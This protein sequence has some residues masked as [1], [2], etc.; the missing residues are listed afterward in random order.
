MSYP[1]RLQIP[2]QVRGV[3]IKESEGQS[4]RS[5][6]EDEDETPSDVPI[7]LRLREGDPLPNVSL[8]KLFSLGL[9]V[10]VLKGHSGYTLV[11]RFV[12]YI[13]KVS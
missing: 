10:Q 3:R 8:P 4:T 6:R 1:D 7:F 12:K 11:V 13:T 9:L 2:G 5:I